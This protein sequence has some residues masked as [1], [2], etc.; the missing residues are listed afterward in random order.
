MSEPAD[1]AFASKT[2]RFTM[3]GL[4]GPGAGT[5]TDHT[6]DS[7]KSATNPDDSHRIVGRSLPTLTRQRDQSVPHI[8]AEDLDPALALQF[9][10]KK[11]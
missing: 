2:E 1:K 5:C 7:I 10:L 6:L 8:P 9:L 3:A 11:G 4:R